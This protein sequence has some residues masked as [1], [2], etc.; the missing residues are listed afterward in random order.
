[1]QNRLLA[2]SSW[3]VLAALVAAPASAQMSMSPIEFGAEARPAGWSF[4]P[5]FNY[6]FVWD[7]NVLFEN[8]GS[9][10]VDEQMHM[11]KPRGVLAFVGRRGEM[12][13]D[14][15]GA[16]VQHPE[17]RSLNSYDQRLG[18]NATRHLSRRASMFARYAGVIAP[19]TELVELVGV[20]F[21]RIGSRRQDLRAG[22]DVALSRSTQ[23][24]ASYN[25]QWIDFA[26]DLEGVNVL[27]GGQSHGV[28]AGVKHVLT[29]RFSLTGD[30]DYT[31][32]KVVDGD[33]FALQNSWGGAEYAVS[34]DM[35]VFAAAGVSHLGAVGGRPAR[36]GP[37]LR[38]GFTR[39]IAPAAL[40]VIYSRSYVPSYSFGG[41]TDN[42]EL[43][44]RVA[45]PISR[46][47]YTA[48]ALSLRRND[49]LDAVGPTLHSTWFYGSV[50]YLL[51]NWVRVEGYTSLARQNIDRP[52]GRI[53]R[54]Q[55]GLQLSAATT[56][57]IR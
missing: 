15:G 48:S 17:L 53:N 16:F 5:A 37:S 14:Y 34:D 49:P 39:D 27:N 3:I 55:F 22:V 7:S 32:A 38:V 10:I 23:V 1:M 26:R 31:D 4:T 50:G 24:N 57:R 56:A 20:P 18:I 13:V 8:V 33:R 11:L 54:Y 2:T 42:E 44:V 40:S 9:D 51:A 28:N 43:G 52:D 19:S 29:R 6:A 47:V 21:V 36:T 12:N 25:F 30:W 45:M 35:R 46:R 41:T